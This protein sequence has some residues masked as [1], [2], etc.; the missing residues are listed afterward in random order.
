MARIDTNKALGSKYR[1]RPEHFSCSHWGDRTG[2][3][4]WQ[5]ANGLVADGTLTAGA[6]RKAVALL[7][8][9]GS[10][11]AFAPDDPATDADEAFGSAFGSPAR[12]PKA[13]KS[14]KPG[15][16]KK[17]SSKKK[18]TTTRKKKKD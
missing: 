4:A 11:G 6:C 14:K 15:P 7:R 3:M 5:R 2:L 1:L 16:K 13:K 9:R 10:N 18:T 17:S 12:Q 8:A